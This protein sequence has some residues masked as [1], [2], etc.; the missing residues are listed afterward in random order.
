MAGIR[1]L[2]DETKIPVLVLSGLD[3]KTDRRKNHMPGI[4]NIFL[5]ADIVP[6]ADAVMFLYRAA[7][8]DSEADPG[9]ASCVVAK[10]P[11]GMMCEVPLLWDEEHAAFGDAVCPSASAAEYG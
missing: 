7:Y 5:S 10:A 8:Y 2:S 4:G 6:Y 11:G 3:R 1:A 9:Q